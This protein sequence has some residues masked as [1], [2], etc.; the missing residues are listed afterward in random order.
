VISFVMRVRDEERTL[1]SVLNRFALI[2]VPYEVIVYLDRCSDRSQEI[3]QNHE[4]RT[5]SEVR[6]FF[7]SYPISRAGLETLVTPAKSQHSIPAF[8]TRCFERARFPWKMHCA[9]DILLGDEFIDFVNAKHLE[10][11]TGPTRI[12]L[13]A[14]SLADGLRNCEPYLSNCLQGF[15]KH[16]FWEVPVFE[17]G[18]EI[19]LDLPL[20]HQGT[21]KEPK[22][23]WN[24]PPWFQQVSYPSAMQIRELY[25]RALEVVPPEPT[26]AARGSNPACDPYLAIVQSKVRALHE[27]GINFY[28]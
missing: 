22:P 19:E 5:G 2:K 13:P 1:D 9:G 14:V 6:V 4:R 28:E 8:L 25:R 17:G 20:Y 18:F 3:A 11:F 16:I 21:L 27:R 15:K 7:N 10:I 26:G 23:Y 12:R 24:D